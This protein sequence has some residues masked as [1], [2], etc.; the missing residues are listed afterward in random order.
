MQSALLWFSIDDFHMT[1]TTVCIVYSLFT[2][3]C[4]AVCWVKQN[5]MTWRYS[6]LSSLPCCLTLTSFA[7]SCLN[8]Y[9]TFNLCYF[10]RGSDCEVLWWVRLCLCVCLYARMS[11]EPHVLSLPMFRACCL[12]PWRGLP[13]ASLWYVMY[14][15]FCRWHYVFSIMGRTTRKHRQSYRHADPRRQ[16]QHASLA[17]VRPW[18]FS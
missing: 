15:L 11:L 9:A 16:Q 5:E 10:A 2:G 17:T 18:R 8:I 13:S 3:D 6:S 1:V 14:F 7:I 12:W 4:G